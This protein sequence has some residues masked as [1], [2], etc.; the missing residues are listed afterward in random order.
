MR[1]RFSTASGTTGQFHFANFLIWC[2]R[3][4]WNRW[5]RLPEHCRNHLTCNASLQWAAHSLVLGHHEQLG[6]KLED[7]VWMQD[8]MTIRRRLEAKP[9]WKICCNP[10]HQETAISFHLA[11]TPKPVPWIQAIQSIRESIQCICLLF[12]EASPTLFSTYWQKPTY[13][14]QYFSIDKTR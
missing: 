1:A 14:N 2:F 9:T 8:Q 12:G 3:E 7:C 5:K 13:K 11:C 10:R 6:A 4:W